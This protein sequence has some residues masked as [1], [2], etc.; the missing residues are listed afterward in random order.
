MREDSGMLWR[1]LLVVMDA[2]CLPVL[3]RTNDESWRWPWL[4]PIQR[5]VYTMRS[6]QHS[7][8]TLNLYH[9][10]WRTYVIGWALNTW[11][12]PPYTIFSFSI[13][14][15]ICTINPI[16]GKL[17]VFHWNEDDLKKTLKYFSS[18]NIDIIARVR[19]S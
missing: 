15:Q 12:T 1:G 8:H 4:A 5:N 14:P 10:D 7:Q 18:E 6:P 13:K 17:E 9:T 3:V 2:W 19:E 11:L 16:W